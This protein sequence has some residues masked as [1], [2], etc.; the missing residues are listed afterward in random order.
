VTIIFLITFL[1]IKGIVMQA[2]QLN[3]PILSTY[4]QLLAYRIFFE[5]G[6][7]SSF[8]VRPN[9]WE[10]DE[11][12]DSLGI[13]MEYEEDEDIRPALKQALKQRFSEL[14]KN[15][16]I[17]EDSSLVEQNIGQVVKG[18]QL[19]D[20]EH[21]ILRFAYYIHNETSVY[22]ALRYLGRRINRQKFIG[23]LAK[24]IEKPVDAVRL[25]LQ[26]NGKLFSFGLIETGSSL[27]HRDFEDHVQWGDTISIDEVGLSAFDEDTLLKSCLQITEPSKLSEENFA[28]IA[29]MRERILSYLRNAYRSEQKGVNILIYGVPGTGKTEF[30]SWIA[31]TLNVPSYTLRYADDDDAGEMHSNKN[32]LTNCTLAQALIKQKQALMIFDEIEDV[33]AGSVFQRSIAQHHKAW[34]NHFLENNPV[35]IVWISNDVSCMDDAFLRRYDIVFKMPD[36]PIQHKE[37]LIRK[38]SDNRLNDGQVLSLAK[39]EHLPAAVLERGFKV[40]KTV[41]EDS[42]AFAEHAIS[43][44]NE[45]LVAQGKSKLQLPK[46]QK[47]SFSLDWV[48]CHGDIHKISQGLIKRQNGRVCCYGPAGTGTTAW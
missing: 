46:H 35:P 45:T 18:L 17:D 48:S 11:L 42:E 26:K 30:A 7:L 8:F 20:T 31:Q 1:V 14:S 24:I 15:P 13:P 22:P 32:R 21:A 12:A 37:S 4:N 27:H 9:R 23:K 3:T 19:N 44:L 39:Q 34:I 6:K 28:H 29:A 2:I 16:L 38:L 41:S 33:F 36:L 43:I 47:A 10:D 5:F 40:A 25:A